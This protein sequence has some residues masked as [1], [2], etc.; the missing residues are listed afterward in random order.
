MGVKMVEFGKTIG[1]I[2]N[3]S[4]N[5]LVYVFK[6]GNVWTDIVLPWSGISSDEYYKSFKDNLKF[7]IGLGDNNDSEFRSKENRN[8]N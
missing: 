7:L 2:T 6:T 4:R 3:K 5:N 1:L 8:T